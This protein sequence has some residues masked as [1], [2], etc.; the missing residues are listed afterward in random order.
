MSI[1]L[2]GLI[3]GLVLGRV[4]AGVMSNFASWRDTYWMA[5]GLQGGES[6]HHV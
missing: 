1:T 6:G 4:L 3:F 2:S 5:V